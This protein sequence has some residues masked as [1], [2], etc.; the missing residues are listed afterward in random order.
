MKDLQ[1][2][3]KRLN[4]KPRK[5]GKTKFGPSRFLHGFLDLLTVW[6]ISKFEDQYLFGSLG[7]FMILTGLYLQYI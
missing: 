4:H 7:L 1:K 6:F 5:H 2:L 3:V